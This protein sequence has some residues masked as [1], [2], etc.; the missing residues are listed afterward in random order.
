MKG[1]STESSQQSQLQVKTIIIN[2]ALV[3]NYSK[4]PRQCAEKGL[5]LSTSTVPRYGPALAV[6]IPQLCRKRHHR[7]HHANK[8]SVSVNKELK[9]SEQ[10]SR[11]HRSLV[12]SCL[13][14]LFTLHVLDKRTPHMSVSCRRLTSIS[15]S[16]GQQHAMRPR[17]SAI[18]I[19]VHCCQPR[20]AVTTTDSRQQR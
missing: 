18:I 2:A 15:R 7:I 17:A 4:G 14:R 6:T 20:T 19:N 3:E 16:R 9:S 12:C 5:M 1:I 8:H 11:F 10:A 13:T